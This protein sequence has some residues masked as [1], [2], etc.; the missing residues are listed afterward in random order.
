[1]DVRPLTE[2]TFFVLAALAD[3]PRHGYGVIAEVQGLSGGRVT[4][5]VGTLYGVLDRLVAEERVALDREEVHAGRL[6]RY[7]R[8]TDAGR[9]ALEAELARQETNARAV[10]ARL[11]VRPA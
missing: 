5:R 2:P 9:L 10:R 11:A 3:R 7:Y 6:R 1:M 4:L 8:L